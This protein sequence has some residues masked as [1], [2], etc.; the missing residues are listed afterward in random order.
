MMG[1]CACVNLLNMFI[2][3]KYFHIDSVKKSYTVTDF[4]SVDKDGINQ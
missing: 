3:N 4:S 2:E 1:V